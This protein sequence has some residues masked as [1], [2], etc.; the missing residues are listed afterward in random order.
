MDH[1]QICWDNKQKGGDLY[2]YYNNLILLR[3]HHPAFRMPNA[4]LIRRHLHFLDPQQACVVAFTLDG[5]AGGD[6]WSRILVVYNGNRHGITLDIPKENWRVCCN[7]D[8]INESGIFNWNR[9]Y[10]NVPASSAMILYT[11]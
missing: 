7:G 8:E 6:L 9:H 3:R 4:E 10:L 1:N 5:H 11:R 2:R